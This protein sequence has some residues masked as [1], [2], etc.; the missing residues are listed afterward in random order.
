[1]EP[2]SPSIVVNYTDADRTVREHIAALSA[3]PRSTESVTLLDSLGRVL[4]TPVLADRDQP[5]FPRSTRDG[6]ACRAAD[7]SSAES[8]FMVGQ[9]RAGEVWAGPPLQPRQVIEIMTGAPVPAGADCVLMVEHAMVDSGGIRADRTLAPGE[10]IVP[11]GA[12][13][14]VG[15]TLVPSGTRIG[16]QHIAAAAACGY[17]DLAV[18]ARPRVAILATGDELVPVASQPLI[19][20]IRNSNSYSIAA[21]VLRHGG[22]PVVYP[23]VRD[24]IDVIESAIEEALTCDLLILSG[25]VSMG[26]YDFVEQ[27]LLDL[28]AEF[29]FTGVRMQ[30]G[31]PVVFGRLPAASAANQDR[32]FFGLPGNP[33]STMVT[34]ALFVAPLLAA[35]AGEASDHIGPGFAEARLAIDITARP[36]LTRFLPAQLKSDSAGATILPVAWQGSGDQAAVSKANCF[37]VIPGQSEDLPAGSTVRIL[38][39]S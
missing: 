23:I 34:F 21:Q 13:A 24:N 1:M 35:L 26:K 33:V 14:H 6:F 22:K 9:L 38:L 17:A 15:A 8:L 5:P 4:A 28:H 12:E 30:P 16:P 32:Y 20:Q 7:L 31:R 25:G 29:F 36:G 27:A 2:A 18:Y 19:H 3:L 11:A 10:N 37:A 39:F